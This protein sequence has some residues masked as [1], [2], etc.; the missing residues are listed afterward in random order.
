MRLAL[1][2]MGRGIALG[3]L[4]KAVGLRATRTLRGAVGGKWQYIR[5]ADTIK[6]AV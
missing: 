4:G 1:R 6:V 3:S 2:G 5:V